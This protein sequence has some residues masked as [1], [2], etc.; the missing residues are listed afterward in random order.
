VITTVGL[1]SLRLV[2]FWLVQRNALCSRLLLG[3]SFLGKQSLINPVV[4]GLQ[5][6]LT[7]CK[8][9]AL[10]VSLFAVHQVQVGHGVVVIRT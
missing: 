7:G 6:F 4:S 1:L 8:V 9:I 5:I 3:F 10:Y 2:L